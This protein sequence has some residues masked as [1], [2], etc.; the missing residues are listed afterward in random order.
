MKYSYFD[1]IKSRRC[2]Q[3]S[4]AE[5]MDIMRSERIVNTCRLVAEKMEGDG[6]AKAAK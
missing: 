4:V 2:R 1:S 3:L 5:L 6:D